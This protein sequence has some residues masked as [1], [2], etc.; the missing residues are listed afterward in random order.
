MGYLMNNNRT[1]YTISGSQPLFVYSQTDKY[2]M[3]IT[4]EPQTPD[5]RSTGIKDAFK[6]ILGDKFNIDRIAEPEQIEQ[7]T[8]DP[9]S[10]IVNVEL[11]E[12]CLIAGKDEDAQLDG[13]LLISTHPDPTTGN[14]YGPT[15]SGL[16]NMVV[17]FFSQKYGETDIET[18][19]EQLAQTEGQEENLGVTDLTM[20]GTTLPPF[21]IPELGQ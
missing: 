5:K 1:V 2:L 10:V 4:R 14:Y 11:G 21:E 20:E 12:N 6:N 19:R 3:G 7:V 13:G 16:P 9:Q 17:N 15:H 18:L 8:Q